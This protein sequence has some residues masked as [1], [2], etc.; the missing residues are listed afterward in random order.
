MDTFGSIDEGFIYKS[1]EGKASL[2]MD[3]YMIC[4]YYTNEYIRPV[5]S[6]QE[7]NFSSSLLKP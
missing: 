3:S 5:T 1:G 2:T 6:G 7:F 4:P